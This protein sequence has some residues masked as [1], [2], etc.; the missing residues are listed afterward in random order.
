ML[1]GTCCQDYGFAGQGALT[2]LGGGWQWGRGAEGDGGPSSGGAARA[3]PGG[4]A[5]RPASPSQA[6]GPGPGL[7][8]APLFPTPSDVSHSP[9]SLCWKQFRFCG[10]RAPR[11]GGRAA[12]G[13]GAF[14]TAGGAGRRGWAGLCSICLHPGGQAAWALPPA[15]PLLPIYGRKDPTPPCNSY[16][17]ARSPKPSSPLLVT[18]RQEQG[19][20]PAFQA[21]GSQTNPTPGELGVGGMPGPSSP[22]RKG[23]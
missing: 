5:P 12:P 1:G 21:P 18:L 10:R 20:E 2:E 7:P 16:S 19:R 6:A 13:A 3:G 17:P 9:G 22:G 15:G 8:S 14:M 4:P 23:R 11:Q